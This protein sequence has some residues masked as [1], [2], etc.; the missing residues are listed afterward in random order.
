[1]ASE[2]L[3]HHKDSPSSA[4]GIMQCP[5]FQSGGDE[6][7]S[8]NPFNEFANL[9][10][11]LHDYMEA[12]LEGR[13]PPEIEG[14]SDEYKEKCEIGAENVTMYCKS[15]NHKALIECE[16]KVKIY[17]VN[18]NVISEGTQDIWCPPNIGGDL[19]GGL[20][21]KPHKH[22]YKPQQ[23]FYALGRMQKSNLDSINWFEYYILPEK[24]KRYV[25][26]MDECVAGVRS[27]FQRKYARNKRPQI[28]YFCRMCSGILYCPAVNRNLKMIAELYKDIEKPEMFHKTGEVI[29][30]L[31]MSKILTFSKDVIEQYL[32]RVKAIT[33][34]IGK[35]ALILNDKGTDIP[36]YRRVSKSSSKITEFDEA[37][38][39]LPEINKEQFQKAMAMSI[40][41]LA[42]TFYQIKKAIFGKKMTKKIAT[43][44]LEARLM[45][46]IE[47]GAP[48]YFL[49]RKMKK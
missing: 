33:V 25:L 39:L 26:T 24:W 18:G 22:D 9:G 29:D 10:T 27:Y 38:G 6:D 21:Y 32:K 16:K 34:K 40:P 31:E 12:L 36:Y 48:S 5:C 45:P 1:M 42:T 37:F 20:D 47:L 46:V 4:P 41:K 2:V 49:E 3:T 19:K 14:F 11:Q 30:G 43:N 13:E 15:I 8:V 17:D 44:Q 7:D 35:D 23:Y 28:C